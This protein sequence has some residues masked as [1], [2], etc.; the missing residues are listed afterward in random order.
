MDFG[1]FVE[2][3]PGKDGLVH[4]SELADYRVAKVEDEVKVGDEVMVKVVEIDRMG[5]INLSRRA[6]IDGDSDSPKP[7]D[8][9][10]SR[11]SDRPPRRS[12]GHNRDRGD[13]G[14]SAPRHFN[15]KR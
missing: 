12:G 10:R 8:R 13:R 7:R 9:D 11:S 15:D 2:I 3:L 1:A 14:R 5:R 6:V 4:I